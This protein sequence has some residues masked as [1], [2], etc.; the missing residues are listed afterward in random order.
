MLRLRAATT[1]V[2]ALLALICTP[3]AA[4]AQSSGTGVTQ[5]LYSYTRSGGLLTDPY[6][7]VPIP[8]LA[9]TLPPK[10][11]DGPK[12]ALITLNMPTLSM[13]CNCSAT[14]AFY[15]AVGAVKFASGEFTVKYPQAGAG[16]FAPM[17][18]VAAI[19]LISSKQVIVAEW[20]SASQGARL[21]L[22][23]WASL[24]ALLVDRLGR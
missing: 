23:P 7:A 20:A 11:E 15:L 2:A 22:G 5:V 3:P 24:S 9:I 17:T 13:S 1:A 8:G 6:K 12:F 18:I 19:P 4:L 16:A 14:G 10:S 21:V